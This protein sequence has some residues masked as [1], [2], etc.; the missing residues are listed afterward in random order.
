[1]YIL[2][3]ERN[4][5]FYVGVTNNL[6]RRVYEHKHGIIPGFTKKYNIH[7][8]VY[9]ETTENIQSAITREKQIKKWNREW[10]LE[11]IENANS[12]WSDL[13]SSLNPVE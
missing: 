1:M 7:L 10:K 2:T 5:I 6:V 13:Y 8:L 11:L 9:Y 4:S 3:R 12:E